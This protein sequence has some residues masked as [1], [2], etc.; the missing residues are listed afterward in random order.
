MLFEQQ[1]SVK[2]ATGNNR[3]FLSTDILEP[4]KKKMVFQSADIGLVYFKPVDLNCKY[5]AGSSGK[6]YDFMQTGVPIIGNDI[7]GMRDLLEGN[8]CGQ[9]IR[10]SREIGAILPIVMANYENF[11]SACCSC[12]PITFYTISFFSER[13]C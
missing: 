6:L 7:P 13:V 10:S 8:Q 11:R 9:V 4:D 12:G 2:I 3:I 5:A 1:I